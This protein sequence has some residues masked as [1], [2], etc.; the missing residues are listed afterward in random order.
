MKKT[1]L[2]SSSGNNI[3]FWAFILY[4][5]LLAIGFL[6][7][8]SVTSDV[9]QSTFHLSQI[10]TRQLIWI[11]GAGLIILT[12]IFANVVIIEYFS[13]YFYGLIIILNIAVLFLGHEVAGAKSWFGFGGFGI[14]P[15]EFAK[16]ATAMALAKFLGTYG[17][18]FRGWKNISIALAIFM[19]PM[20]I[21]L[22]QN[23]TGSA[24]VYLSFFLVVYREGM[25]GYFLI[26]AIW[27]GILGIISIIFQSYNIS[28]GYLHGLFLGLG[29][30]LV[31][32]S[33]KN[34]QIVL[35]VLI[36]SI[37]SSLFSGV[38]GWAYGKLFKNYQKDRIEIVLGL[39]EDK[40]GMGY[41]LE[42]SKIA[43]G[44]G[45]LSG[46]GFTKGTQTKMGFVPEQHTDFIFCTIGE[47]WGFLG[48]FVFFSAF[49][50]LMIRLIYLAERQSDSYGRVLGYS[51]CCILFFHFFINIGMTIG[52]VPVIGIPLPFVSFGGSSL[53][54]FTLLLFTFLRYDQIRKN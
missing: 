45:G 19:L 8:Y 16:V 25:P 12:I 50:S 17:I 29:S 20:L 3:D 7:I 18:K 14:Q 13:Y 30:I 11:G 39:K 23:D 27:L 9:N 21:I 47:E 42:Q 26:A 10:A 6:N 43:I 22:I 52:L 53:W 32:F 5:F 51:A 34:R 33:R 46:R 15:S 54:G 49:V 36:I 2:R 37:G 40:R 28:L 38:V 41:N 44:A 48:V 1:S 31:Y 4:V 24:L 35:L